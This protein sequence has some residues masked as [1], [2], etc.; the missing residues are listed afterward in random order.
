MI[1]RGDLRS[2]A[3]L[4]HWVNKLYARYEHFVPAFHNTKPAYWHEKL[5]ISHWMRLTGSP[6]LVNYSVIY[7]VFQTGSRD[8]PST[9]RVATKSDVE[10][11]S[12]LRRNRLPRMANPARRIHHPGPVAVCSRAHRWRVASTPGLRPHRRRRARACPGR[13]LCPSG[14]HPTR[15]PRSFPQ[16]HPARIHP[17]PRS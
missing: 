1:L 7:P 17:Y 12:R 4:D 2:L 15:Q 10:T 9:D 8:R 3:P 13:Q 16:S 14:A 11:Y 5:S 6:L